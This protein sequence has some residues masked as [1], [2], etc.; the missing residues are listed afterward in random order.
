MFHINKKGGKAFNLINSREALGNEKEKKEKR[1]P[2][3]PLG[4]GKVVKP[5]CDSKTEENSK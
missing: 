5:K 3:T 4:R 2:A 1:L